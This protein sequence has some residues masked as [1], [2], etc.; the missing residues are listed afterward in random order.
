MFGSNNKDRRTSHYEKINY[1]THEQTK[2]GKHKREE[3]IGKERKNKTA[4]VKWG[5][6]KTRGKW[7]IM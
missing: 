7:Q 5:E 4:R 3:K 1:L 6:R 2:K